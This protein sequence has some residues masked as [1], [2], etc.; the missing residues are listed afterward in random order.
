MGFYSK[1]VCILLNKVTHTYSAE[2]K[3]FWKN[4]DNK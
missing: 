3:P 4:E 1:L 2:Y